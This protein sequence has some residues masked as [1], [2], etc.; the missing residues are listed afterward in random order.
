V[1][2]LVVTHDELDH[3]I[4]GADTYAGGTPRLELG[5]REEIARVQAMN[6]CCSISYE[7]AIYMSMRRWRMKPVSEDSW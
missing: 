1:H 2:L 7:I 6:G 4:Q 5:Q 3:L